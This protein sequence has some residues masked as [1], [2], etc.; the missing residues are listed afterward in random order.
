M[1]PRCE[2]LTL[3]ALPVLLAVVTGPPSLTGLRSPDPMGPLLAVLGALAWAAV[4]WLLLVLA[5]TWCARDGRRL[6]VTLLRVLAPASVQW[7]ARAAL[8]LVVGAAALS[9]TP[10]LAAPVAPPPMD[11]D[12]T[13]ALPTPTATPDLTPRAP[14]R[15]PVRSEP[16]APHRVTRAPAATPVGVRVVVQRGDSLWA[17]AARALG[18]SASTRQIAQDWPQWWRANAAQIGSNPDLIHPG[19]VL[20]QPATHGES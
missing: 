5:L 18:P 11:L 13:G 10:A 9:T 17:I 3:L 15:P 20:L 14:S 16:A 19:A 1:S 6:A 2:A 12:W 4:S 8:G 7:A